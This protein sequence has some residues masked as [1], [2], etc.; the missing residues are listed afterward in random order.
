M[1]VDLPQKSRRYRQLMDAAEEY[2][3]LLRT[4]GSLPDDVEAAEQ[5]LNMLSEPFGDDPAFQAL[6]R[7]ERKTKPG[8]G[9]GATG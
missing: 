4:P 1:G 7:I 6:L 5:R 9:S 2:F 3:H 8:G